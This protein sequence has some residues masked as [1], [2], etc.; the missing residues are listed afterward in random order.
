MLCLDDGVITVN[1]KGMM[2]TLA[3]QNKGLL[4]TAGDESGICDHVDSKT[5]T[6]AKESKV[7]KATVNKLKLVLGNSYFWVQGLRRM[8]SVLIEVAFLQVVFS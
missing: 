4:G 1:Q 6:E 3:L 5:P 2:K 7:S 8:I